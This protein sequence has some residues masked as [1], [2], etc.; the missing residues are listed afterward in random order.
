MYPASAPNPP[1]LPPQAAA[2]YGDG[3]QQVGQQVGSSPFMPP[4]M[5]PGSFVSMNAEMSRQPLGEVGAL[6]GAWGVLFVQSPNP[7]HSRRRTPSFPGYA[8]T[9][10]ST[11]CWKPGMEMDTDS[12]ISSTIQIVM[13]FP[14][15]P[16]A[17]RFDIRTE[18]VFLSAPMPLHIL[19]STPR[20]FSHL[21]I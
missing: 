9:P 13:A 16:E 12:D 2:S 14:A 5:V 20:S 21:V 15:F 8:H 7:F 19:P 17:L 6:Q 11:C 10:A 4:V 18:A 1:P 3:Y